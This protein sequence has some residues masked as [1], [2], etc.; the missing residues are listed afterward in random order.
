MAAQWVSRYPAGCYSGQL[1]GEI[2]QG[3]AATDEQD[4]TEEGYG[5]LFAGS[6]ERP[7][8]RPFR[9]VHPPNS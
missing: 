1:K 7:H 4:E 5:F 8:V 6:S 9:A 3:N 2:V